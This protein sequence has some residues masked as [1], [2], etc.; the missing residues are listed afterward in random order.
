M[1]LNPTS[2]SWSIIGSLKVKRIAMS[3]TATYV[4]THDGK[5]KEFAGVLWTELK[6]VI[7]SDIAVNQDADQENHV[8]V[9]SNIEN[10]FAGYT[11]HKWSA[12]ESTWIE[13]E[14]AIPNPAK[15]AVDFQGN[16]WIVDV[17]GEIH[18]FTGNEWIK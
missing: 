13:F 2:G 11:L 15:L 7:A 4:I 14:Y 18:G 6:G 5:V 1:R 16:P 3:S 10:P 9:I 17:Y 8:F 12:T